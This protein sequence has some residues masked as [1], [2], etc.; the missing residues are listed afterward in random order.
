[1]CVAQ[2]WNQ[3]WQTTLAECSGKHATVCKKHAEH[4]TSSICGSNDIEQTFHLGSVKWA[5][6]SISTKTSLQENNLPLSLYLVAIYLHYH[7]LIILLPSG[8]SSLYFHSKGATA[9][10]PFAMIWCD[11][12]SL[13]LV[14]S[15]N[16]WYGLKWSKFLIL[17]FGGCM[18]QCLFTN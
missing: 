10:G 12:Q 8:H 6:G 2:T 18:V 5:V 3:W 16:H 14:I 11:S 15:S 7:I 1:M 17:S 9:S 4:A 13:S